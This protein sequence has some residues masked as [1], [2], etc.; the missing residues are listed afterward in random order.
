MVISVLSP[1]A[2]ALAV[3]NDTFYG[4]GKSDVQVWSGGVG[5]GTTAIRTPG[6]DLS[7]GLRM[8]RLHGSLRL[9][10]MGYRNA[11]ATVTGLD[12]RIPMSLNL[13]G[14][15]SDLGIGDLPNGNYFLLVRGASGIQVTK[16]VK[17]RNPLSGYRDRARSPWDGPGSSPRPRADRPACPRGAPGLRRH[18]PESGY[19]SP[20]R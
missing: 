4:V 17:Y 9:H 6:P 15:D 18:G 5:P 16:F 2:N 14:A 10:S 8:D 12:G 19:R 7:S 1:G 13:T 3:R 20:P 11:T